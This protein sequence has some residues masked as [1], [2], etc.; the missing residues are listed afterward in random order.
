MLLD[1]SSLLSFLKLVDEELEE[2]ITIIAVGGTAMTLLGLKSSTID[3]DFNF[4][5]RNDL[6]VFDRAMNILNPGF[7]IDKFL[8]SQ[9]FSQ[10]IPD[11]YEKKALQIKVDVKR[12]KI[13]TLHPLDIIVTKIGRLSDRDVE[14]IKICIDRY[15]LTKEQVRKRGETVEEAGNEAVYRE[16]LEYVLKN[17]FK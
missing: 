17:F 5:T 4:P 13:F 2:Q 9:I 12:L 6:E 14:D 10:K 16:N 1:R 8:G 15:E 3:V 7:R 11:D